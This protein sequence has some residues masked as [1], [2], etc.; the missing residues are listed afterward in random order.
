[1]KLITLHMV[2]ILCV[3]ALFMGMSQTC[4]AQGKLV[5]LATIEYPPFTGQN[6]KN[7]GALAELA[8][9]AFKLSG[10]SVEI[11][12]LPWMRGLEMTKFGDYDGLM[13]MWYRPEREKFFIFSESTEANQIVLF[14]RK[15]NPANFST[16]EDLKRYSIGIV[17]GYANP[18]EFDAMIEQ[19][20]VEAVEGEITNI[21]K[22]LGGRVDLVLMD[23]KVGWYMINTVFPE[24]ADLLISLPKV[25]KN[26]PIYIGFSRAVPDIQTKVDAFNQGIKT[27]RESGEYKSILERHNL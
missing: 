16:Y 13:D 22:L 21:K 2:K 17:R 25:L 9:A 11:T 7:G 26:D 18:P 4:T 15:D 27:L 24:Q 3:T 10:Y 8:V 5:R 20:N 23:L 12:Y 19:L 1:M 6:L 14:K